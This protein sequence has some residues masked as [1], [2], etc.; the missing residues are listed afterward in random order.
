MSVSVQVSEVIERP[1]E[2]VF[3]FYAVEHVQNHPRWDP[4]MQLEKVTDGPIGVGTVIKRVNSRS[5][6][7]VEGT[8]EVEE[9]ESNQSMSMIIHDGPMEMRGRATVEPESDERTKLIIDVEIPGMHEAMDTSM[10]SD[11]MQQSLRNIKQLIESEA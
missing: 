11:G 1:V 4:Y 9:F 5:G 6:S 2:D 3:R 7:P 8:M 10:L